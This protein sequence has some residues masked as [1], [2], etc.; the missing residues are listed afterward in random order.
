MRGQ[1]FLINLIT[2]DGL[3]SAIHFMMTF[4]NRNLTDS[5]IVT[6]SNSLYNHSLLDRYIYYLLIY[7]LYRILH[8]FFWLDNFTF[9]SYALTYIGLLTIIPRVINILLS[10]KWF[11][12][13]REKKELMVKTI[14]SKIFTAI[15]KVCS[16][17][18]LDKDLEMKHSEILVLLT[19]Y[20]DAIQYFWDVLKNSLV[21]LG[22][23][24]VKN[25]SAPLYYNIIKYVYNYKT[26]DLVAS[27]NANT[28]KV[29]LIDIIDNRQW[30]ELI[31]PNA[32][33]AMM[34]LYQNSEKI[35]DVQKV[36]NNFN[37]SLVK[38]FTVWTLASLVDFIYL[39]P[40]ISF[41]LLIYRNDFNTRKIII[42]ILA[43]MLSYLYPSF[44][45]ISAI[46]H[47]GE[48]IVFN[49]LTYLIAKIFVKKIKKAWNH[50]VHNNRDLLTSHLITVF[51]ILFL[52][53]FNK[54]DYLLIGL[55]ILANMLMNISVRKQIIF[56]LIVISSYL[57]EYNL[58]HILFNSSILYLGTGLITWNFDIMDY[59]YVLSLPIWENLT[60]FYN[61]YDEF[62]QKT[63][64]T[65]KNIL[66][67]QNEI[68]VKDPDIMI[69][70]R[71]SIE[72]EVF[73]KPDDDFIN[74]ISVDDKEF[75]VEMINSYSVVNN[76]YT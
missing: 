14:I 51:Y 38:M 32:C 58:V 55:N 18:Y 3:F 22:L 36:V 27:Y 5:Q 70:K 56:G 35:S 31:K 42:L 67:Q 49:K 33:K 7:G 10:Y 2:L 68:I 29:Y 74:D 37:F 19:D 76:F 46:C 15:I 60:H 45:I 41:G 23:S 40:I 30:G 13:V 8:I 54:I 28:A 24:Y 34:H 21:M 50:I 64:S 17:L 47:Y 48:R 39:V 25:Y 52:K 66:F 12:Y 61:H 75:T 63:R 44:M 20:R 16:K 73:D 59:I 53:Y 9:I 72:D 62:R 57:S 43:T 71:V 4:I 69:E 26:G 1:D 11:N 65:V 6:I